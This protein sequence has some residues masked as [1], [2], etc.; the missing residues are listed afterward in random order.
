MENMRCSAS[1]SAPGN[2][3]IRQAWQCDGREVV[4]TIG[5]IELVSAITQARPSNLT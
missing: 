5:E 1:E 2:C 4:M 3:E